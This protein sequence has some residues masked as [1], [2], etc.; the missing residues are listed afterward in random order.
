MSTTLPAT[1]DFITSLMSSLP[2]LSQAA[3][4]S[5]NPLKD[6]PSS[7]QNVFLTL[8]VLFPNEL[9]PA[10]DVLDR[11]LVTRLCLKSTD[12][13]VNDATA[14]TQAAT[15][16]SST[17]PKAH[18]APDTEAPTTTSSLTQQLYY[19][20]S[21]QQSSRNSNS[22]NPSSRYR[23]AAYETT[24]Y[25]EV[26]LQAWTC[27]CPAFA[28]S[29]FPAS[30]APSHRSNKLENAWPDAK[31]SSWRFGG[32][33]LG[34]DLAVCKHLLACV[35]IEHVSLFASCVTERSVS[36]EEMAGWAAG[37]GD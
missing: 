28:F 20:Q 12:T 26:R 29:A 23:N 16:E 9:L 27:S 3:D 15:A 34:E 37:W 2:N 8:H 21:A 24:A 7:D 6:L 5:S 4:T 10:L 11:N 22:N 1:R 13:Q 18:D 19:V 17:A 14:P 33:T 31:C 35:L 25:Y 32:L 36:V 30:R